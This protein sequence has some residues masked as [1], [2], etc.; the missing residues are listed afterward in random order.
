MGQSQNRF[1]NSQRWLYLFYVVIVFSAVVKTIT[2]FGD[3]QL[4]E[5]AK[6]N[7]EFN[8]RWLAWRSTE[9]S[10]RSSLDI[11]GFHHT[12]GQVVIDSDQLESDYRKHIERMRRSIRTLQSFSVP[13]S[14]SSECGTIY[15]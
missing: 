8:D 9:D 6:A 3:K 14:S 7:I 10:I 15:S 12:K 11:I 2:Y 13:P 1:G 4:E 5:G